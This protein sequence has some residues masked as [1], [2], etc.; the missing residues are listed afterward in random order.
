MHEIIAAR[1]EW[2]QSVM[3]GVP[4]T[5]T[6]IAALIHAASYF[7]N[8]KLPQKFIFIITAFHLLETCISL[9][10]LASIQIH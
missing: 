1:K 8:S 10:K 4:D 5:L 9:S 6:V 3:R 2:E 7:L